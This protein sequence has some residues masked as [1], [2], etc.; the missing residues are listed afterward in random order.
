DA[1]TMPHPGDFDPRSVKTG[2]LKD[3]TKID[4]KIQEAFD[5][6]RERLGNYK[7]EAMRAE[8]NYWSD[9]SSKA[10][11][12][13]ATG[14]VVAIGCKR[15]SKVSIS[16]IDE[17][18]TEAQMLAQFWHLY[19][20]LRKSDRNLVGFNSNEFDVPF[21]A[22]R[23]VVLGVPVPKTLIKQGRYLDE[24][25]VDL[26]KVWS[27]GAK[28]VGSLDMVCRACGIPGKPEGVNGA[29]FADLYFNPD[30]RDEAIEYLENDLEM[31]F[32]LAER[33]L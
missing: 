32:S 16:A 33:L 11:L 14:R 10:A 15:H 25:F 28:P 19:E 27:F 12:S 3:Q 5:S 20:Q 8:Q 29:M 24:M 22:Q 26:R 17:E 6:H 30:T 1:S 13:A 9:A 4:A 31:T 7:F 2:N 18:T 21:L 23:S